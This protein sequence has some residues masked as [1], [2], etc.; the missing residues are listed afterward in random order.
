MEQLS[1]VDNFSRNKTPSFMNL[2]SAL[3]CRI[4]NEITILGLSSQ[5]RKLE[6]ME[7]WLRQYLLHESEFHHR[8]SHDVR[9]TVSAGPQGPQTNGSGAQTPMASDAQRG[10]NIG[11]DG[12][13]QKTKECESEL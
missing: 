5:K 8:G 11:A 6:K 1:I 7:L 12:S 3:F 4:K 9:R 2:R 13:H 10:L